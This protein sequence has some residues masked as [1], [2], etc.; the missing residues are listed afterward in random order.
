MS[1]ELL[2]QQKFLVAYAE[3]AIFIAF[4][5][6]ETLDDLATDL[7]TVNHPKFGG[8]FHAGFF[9]RADVFMGSD[10]NPMKGLLSLNKRII[11]CGHSLGG[12]VAHMVLLRYLLENNWNLD[13]VSHYSQHPCS[14]CSQVTLL[15]QVP[16][17]L[18]LNG[19]TSMF[20]D[21]YYSV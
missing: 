5:G 2:G 11:F 4:R 18:Q 20:V 9:E 14:T 3:D 10:Q 8:A 15:V 12:A 1:L 17:A 19:S 16:L 7:K 6:T 13:E 21:I